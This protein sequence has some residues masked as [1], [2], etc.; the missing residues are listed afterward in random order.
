MWSTLKYDHLHF[1]YHLMRKILA[2]NKKN[3]S[4]FVINLNYFLV[5]QIIIL[6]P[7]PFSWIANFE[8]FDPFFKNFLQK[9]LFPGLP[10][11][12]EAISIQ[13]SSTKVV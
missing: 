8:C 2:L 1:K 6:I 12:I 7:F 10:V 11:L 13:S 4:K 9:F 5:V 3:S